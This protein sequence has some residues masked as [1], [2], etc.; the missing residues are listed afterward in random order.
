M[1]RNNVEAG[2]KNGGDRETSLLGLS[3]REPRAGGA[4]V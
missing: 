1:L 4:G 3:T 2:M